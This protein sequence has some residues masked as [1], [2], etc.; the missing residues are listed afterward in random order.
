[1]ATSLL[2]HVLKEVLLNR[3]IIGETREGGRGGGDGSL[4]LGGRGDTHLGEAGD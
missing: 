1:M 2:I 4:S 3:F